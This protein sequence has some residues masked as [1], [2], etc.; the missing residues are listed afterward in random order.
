[1][2]LQLNYLY[3][4]N[5]K[6]FKKTEI[7][8]LPK[9]GHNSN[10]RSYY[11]NINYSVFVGE[12]GVGKTTVMSFLCSIFH[13]LQRHHNRIESDFT[14]KY[15][16]T[17]T[18]KSEFTI[19][20]QKLDKN[21]FISLEG[22]KYLLLE[23]NIKKK[24][25]GR[26]FNQK[27]IKNVITYDDIRYLLPDNIVASVFSFNK[28]Y[29]ESWN[30]NYI[31][32]RIIKHHKTS[33][34]YDSSVLGLGISLGKIKFLIYLFNNEKMYRT[35]L[36][37]LGFK[38][39]KTIDIHFSERKFNYDKN[40][41]IYWDKLPKMS[42]YK[43]WEDFLRQNKFKSKSDFLNYIYSEDFW[44]KYTFIADSDRF[45]EKECLDIKKF[46]ETKDYNASILLKLIELEQVYI[47]NIYFYKGEKLLSLNDFSSGEKIF[48]YRI[49]S[50]LTSIKENSLVII[51][52]PELHLNPSWTKQ[53]IT[54]FTQLFGQFGAHFI[55]ATHSY[56]FINT[57]FPENIL[58]VTEEGISFPKFNTFLANEKEITSKLFPKTFDL[59]YTEERFINELES[60]NIEK[61]ENIMNYLGE[62]YYRFQTYKKLMEMKE[63]R[64]NVESNE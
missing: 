63:E 31:G 32:D 24:S 64:K 22:K 2:S 43:S 15:Q 4:E 20:I 13:Y 23:W 51:E 61:V 9:E 28:E 57:L 48:I 50:I 56:Y 33:L 55:L 6:R 60:N 29:P 21:V 44:G 46:L 40:N 53:I 3:I 35:V 52:E 45:E 30:Y 47:N 11:K 17:P 37:V 42:N 59:N 16:I 27:N 8:F 62:S 38:I 58:H 10:Y 41:E 19:E 7:F 1:M 25:Y 12:N 26:K 54:L 39:A 14:L 49:L 36:D 34:L 18:G 5:F